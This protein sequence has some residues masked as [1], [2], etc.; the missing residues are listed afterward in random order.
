MISLRK[1]L[2]SRQ[3]TAY[4]FCACVLVVHAWELY[5]LIYNVPAIHHRETTWDLLGII[6]IVQAFALFE[7]LVVFLLLSGLAI[8][9]PERLVRRQFV[10]Q[11]SGALLVSA[12]WAMGVHFTGQ[13]M[14][15]WAAPK[16]WLWGGLYLASLALAWWGVRRFPRLDRAIQRV[17]AEAS[18]LA[19]VYVVLG[20]AALAIILIRNLS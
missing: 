9:L 1:R 17:T 10:S 16:L 4:V 15:T 6:A 18:V 11:A 13:P 2:P 8:L 5:N 7:S 3:S 19:W 20:L 14:T 12:G